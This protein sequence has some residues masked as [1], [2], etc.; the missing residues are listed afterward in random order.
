MRHK[1]GIKLFKL[2]SKG[3][4]TNRFI[5]YAGRDKDRQ[6][7]V[8]ESIVMRLMNGLLDCGR[9][10]FA[11]NFYTSIPLAEILIARNTHYVGTLRKNRIGIPKEIV[12][13]KLKKSEDI[14]LQNNKGIAIM[15]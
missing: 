11:D 4:Y 13:K 10:L 1:F 3:G 8:A 5:V 14:Y 7:S 12:I 9:K 6:G 15:K 2:C